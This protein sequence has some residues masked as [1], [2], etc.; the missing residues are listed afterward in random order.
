MLRNIGL[1]NFSLIYFYFFTITFIISTSSLARGFKEGNNVKAG[2]PAKTTCDW[3]C[4]IVV[5]IA[6]IF[7]MDRFERGLM[8]S[9]NFHPQI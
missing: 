1:L 8:D 5:A 4:T 6:N 7:L 3:R 9:I 2:T